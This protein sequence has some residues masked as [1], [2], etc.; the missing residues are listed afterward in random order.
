MVFITAALCAVLA[1]CTIAVADED[2]VQPEVLAKELV[3]RKT[4]PAIFY[5]GFPVLYRN[6]RIPGARYA[7]QGSTDT[8][9][10]GLR[11]ELDKLPRSSELVLY[12]GCCPWDHCP[13]IRPAAKLARDMGFRKLKV[14]MIPASFHLDWAQKGYPTD[15][16]PLPATSVKQ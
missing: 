1:S 13:N 8:G 10:A 7:G 3:A 14:L 9:L 2:L 15:R 5:V 6:S 16:N 4:Q 11:A 12:C